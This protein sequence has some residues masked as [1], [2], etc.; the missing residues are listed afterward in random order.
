MLKQIM[1]IQ[2]VGLFFDSGASP[3]LERISL[4]Y[5]ENGRGKSTLAS[6]LRACA[7]NRTDLIQSRKTLDAEVGQ[8][9]QI[10]LSVDKGA[11]V[12]A[13]YDSAAHRGWTSSYSDLRVFDAE[14]VS[15]NVYSG[16]EINSDREIEALKA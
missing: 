9:V 11:A 6:I 14:F 8:L 15:R 4:F 10:A 1:S 5:G 12:E 16:A 7:E 13:L 3:E 2:G